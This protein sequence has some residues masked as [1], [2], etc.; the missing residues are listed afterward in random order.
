MAQLTPTTGTTV[1]SWG[2][3][4]LGGC[5]AIAGSA[6]FGTLIASV[7]LRLSMAEGL[8]LEQANSALASGG[9]SVF[10]VLAPLL[11]LL[12]GVAGGYVAAKYGCAKA[13]AQAAAASLFP[14]LFMAVMYVNPGSQ[15]GPAWYVAYSLVSPVLASLAGGLFLCQTNL[16]CQSTRTPKAVRL[17]RSPP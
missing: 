6:F 14:L 9:V 3:A 10:T 13:L 11:S 8:S 16:T 12:A 17:L 4:T 1:F 2:A 15:S 5:V 7:S